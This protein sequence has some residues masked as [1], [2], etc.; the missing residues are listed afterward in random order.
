ML[1]LAAFSGRVIATHYENWPKTK[2]NIFYI[3][4]V[5]NE[6]CTVCRKR[7]QMIKA[8]FKT[9]LAVERCYVNFI[10]NVLAYS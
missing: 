10:A 4:F 6:E 8:Y 7:F 3:A 2:R 1:T 9:T 5:R